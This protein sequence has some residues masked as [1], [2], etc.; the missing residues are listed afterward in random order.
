MKQ[1]HA[2]CLGVVPLVDEDFGR[3]VC[4]ID[5]YFSHVGRPVALKQA[6]NLGLSALIVE[7]AIAELVILIVIRC[8]L[9]VVGY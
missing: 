7:M 4:V 9:F 5:R 1:R 6:S 2:A 8:W 3:L